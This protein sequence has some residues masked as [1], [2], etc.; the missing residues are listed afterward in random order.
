MGGGGTGGETK[1]CPKFKTRLSLRAT[2]AGSA[3]RK[4][5]GTQP[6]RRLPV[7]FRPRWK[8][9]GGV[10]TSSDAHEPLRVD[11]NTNIIA[12]EFWTGC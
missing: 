1:E 12:A 4:C 10:N 8:E 5:Q 7:P 6:S 2:L 11:V 3:V 9:L